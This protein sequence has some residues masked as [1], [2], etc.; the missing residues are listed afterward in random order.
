MG[1][2]VVVILNA[3]AGADE[4]TTELSRA[5]RDKLNSGG[6]DARVALVKSQDIVAEATRAVADK[7]RILV[8]GGGDG[9]VNAIASLVVD[10]EIILGVL[11]LGTLNHFAKDLHIPLAIDDAIA[12]IIAGH[13]TRVDVGE[14]NGRIFVNNSSE[15]LYPSIV[16]R[17]DR[18]MTRLGR[19][20]WPAFLWAAIA[21]LR[22]YPFL[23]VRL[24]VDD[25]TLAR[26]TPFVFVGNNEYLVEGFRIGERARLDA[27]E[28]SLYVANRTTRFGLL[29]LAVHALLGRLKQVTDF[30]VVRA[31]E[32]WIETSHKQI[33]VATDGEVSL[34]KTPLHYRVRPRALRVL[35]PRPVDAVAGPSLPEGR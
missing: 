35:V 14:V 11:P 25:R 31:K 16:R 2:E 3:H 19:G 27:G 32:V 8:A 26:R 18:Q 34:M 9:T 15:G 33:G 20:K 1:S 13:D 28:L 29:R 5:I 24:S 10:S 4:K 30:D 17:R 6:L 21:M 7:P 23:D 22:R 12:N